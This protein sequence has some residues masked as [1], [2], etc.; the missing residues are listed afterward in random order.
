MTWLRGWEGVRWL[1]SENPDLA[2]KEVL[3]VVGAIAD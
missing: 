1:D 2:R 3:Q